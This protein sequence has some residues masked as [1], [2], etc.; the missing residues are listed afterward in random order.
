MR[1]EYGELSDKYDYP[2]SIIEVLY[3]LNKN[4]TTLK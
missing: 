2:D 4:F 3:Q 1:N